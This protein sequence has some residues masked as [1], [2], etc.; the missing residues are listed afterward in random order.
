MDR[1]IKISL[2]LLSIHI[3]TI[4]AAAGDYDGS[5]PLLFS[6]VKVFECTNEDACREVTPES[7]NLPQF[8]K[9][10]FDQK[11]II[12][13]SESTARPPTV[14]ERIE[15]VDGKLILQGAEDSLENVRDGVGWTMAISEETGKTVLTAS[16]EQI[17]FVVFGACIAQ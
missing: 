13:P 2:I 8:L 17:G 15:K 12:P 1:L 7:V 3:F 10:D 5:K 11:T 14:I 6:V 16:G 4:A 9:I